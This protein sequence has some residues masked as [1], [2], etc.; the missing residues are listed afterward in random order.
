MKTIKRW[1]SSRLEPSFLTNNSEQ[2]HP[3]IY[4]SSNHCHQIIEYQRRLSKMKLSA[5]FLALMACQAVGVFSI[6]SDADAA[7]CGALGVMDWNQADIPENV[8]RDELRKCREHPTDAKHLEARKGFK[9][10]PKPKKGGGSCVDKGS[11]GCHDGY[12]WEECHGGKWC[13][14]AYT[15]GRGDWISCKKKSDCTGKHMSRAK[16]GVGS[17]KAC[18]C[19][20]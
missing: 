15:D 11:W 19:G 12:C 8:S 1:A 3:I 18:G 10:K 4:I 9:P 5:T 20:C 16:C 2:A 14:L 13:W 7:Q 17:C 6:P